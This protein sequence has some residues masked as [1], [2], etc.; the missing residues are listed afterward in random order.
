MKTIRKIIRP[1]IVVALCLAIAVTVMAAGLVSGYAGEHGTIRGTLRQNDININATVSITTGT[2]TAYVCNTISTYRDSIHVD[3]SF[4]K[5]ALKATSLNSTL[6]P[7]FTLDNEPNMAY[8]AHE[9]RCSITGC[10]Y[11]VYSSIELDWP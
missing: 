7:R 10:G 11:V 9:V 5:S 6:S 1:F 3:E 2:S 8:G 4:A